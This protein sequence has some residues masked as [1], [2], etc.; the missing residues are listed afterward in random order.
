M[1]PDQSAV[2]SSS[3]IIV[4]LRYLKV[5]T[6]HKLLISLN[7]LVPENS[8]WDINR[9]R[10][11]VIVNE[12]REITRISDIRGILRY[13]SSRYQELTVVKYVMKELLSSGT[14]CSKHC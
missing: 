6:P 11:G 8:L 2:L 13:Q 7:F 5:E 12:N 9:L 10:C 4:N 14:S 3:N 1:Q